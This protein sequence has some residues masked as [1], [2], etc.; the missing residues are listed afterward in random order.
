MDSR[1]EEGNRLEKTITRIEARLNGTLSFA[2]AKADS[3][4]VTLALLRIMVAHAQSIVTVCATPYAEATGA[5]VRAM[6]E[7]WIEIYSI[8]EPGKEE[9]NARR[10]VVFGL[11]EFRDHSIATGHLDQAEL[12]RI[13]DE[14]ASYRAIHGL[15]VADIEALR[16]GKGKRNRHYWT[17]KSRS[18]L[19]KGMEDQG[20]ASTLRSIYKMLSWDAH[21]VIAAALQSS[22]QTDAK[23]DIQVSFHPL[24]LAEDTA[25]FNRYL[26][27]QMLVRACLQV[28]KHLAVDL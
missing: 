27:V 25:A 1:L 18:A 16:S 26:A 9:E 6:M 4:A 10:S 17:G 11:L 22:V 24:A 28:G 2:D 14:L 7:A 13:N 23:G 12:D 3:A 21:H 20:V 5:N 8:L 15:L 19:L